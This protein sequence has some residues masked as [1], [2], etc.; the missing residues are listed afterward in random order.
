MT[1]E[2]SGNAAAMTTAIQATASRRLRGAGGDDAGPTAD[3]LVNRLSRAKWI[4]SAPSA[5]TANMGA[6]VHELVTGGIDVSPLLTHT[7]KDDR[8]Q[9]CLRRRGRPVKSM[10]VHL[11][12]G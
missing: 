5:L 12:F 6:A 3:I 4:C 9:R 11:V 2:C 1:F 7:F 8:G 10:K